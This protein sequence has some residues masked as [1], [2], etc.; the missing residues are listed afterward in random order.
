MSRINTNVA[1]L[2][3]ARYLNQNNADLKTS[4]ERLSTG[5][6]INRG[7]DDPAGLIASENLRSEMVGIKAA[8]A[9]AERANSI[10]ATA[11]G[12]LAEVSDLLGD[13]QSLAVQSANAGGLNAEEIRANQL[14]VDGI[15]DSID[16]IASQTSFNG[17]RLLDGSKGFRT[18]TAGGTVRDVTV[19]AAKGVADADLTVNVEVVTAAAKADGGALAD[20]DADGAGE[21]VT[22][23]ITG[24]KGSATITV[25]DGTTAADLG[26]AVNAL[27]GIT[28]VIV[29]GGELVSK[30]FGADEF[31]RVE[32]V[33]GTNNAG[34]TEGLNTTSAG[35]D[36][37]VTINNA[38]ASVD[39]Y[40]AS[41]RTPT[42]DI[43]FTMTDDLVDTAANTE[44][45]TVEKGGG[46]TFQLS[47]NIGV[48]G[49]EVVGLPS[50]FTTKLGAASEG[51]LSDI[52]SGGANDLRTDAAGAQTIIEAATEQ[53]ATA[54]GRLGS[55]IKDTVQTTINSLNVAYENVAAADSVIRETDFASETARLTRNQIL[56]NA[57][58]SVL[59]IANA[60]PQ[61]VLSLIG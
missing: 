19:N 59:S 56:V 51:V 38:V 5:Y 11:E 21:S 49:Q 43:E 12:A 3:S 27:S 30:A 7:S 57:S 24:A 22:Y 40:T 16:R 6:R 54:R 4:L 25:A 8:M 55:F 44:T 53:I 26:D 48:T 58:T 23:E 13:L 28:G 36:A 33:A 9:N 20:V 15:L 45:I 39:G 14:Q 31:V 50:V 41:V 52:A 17:E 37:V 32:V 34:L 61:S 46:A 18:S 35:A 47:P 10:V 1:S 29:S 60:T 2:V 42:L